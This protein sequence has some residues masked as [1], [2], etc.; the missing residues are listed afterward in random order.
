MPR[1]MS[2]IKH[3]YPEQFFLFDSPYL[4]TLV[5][6]I[7]QQSTTQPQFNQLIKSVY[8]TMLVTALNQEWPRSKVEIET[9]MTSL[10]PDQRLTS[11]VFN[12]NQKA[13]CVD[14]ARAGMLPSQVFFDEL[15]ELVD[16]VKIRQ[17][18]IFAARMTDSENQVTHTELNSSKIG[19]DVDQCLVFLPDPMGATGL[20][21]CQVID[22]YKKQVP[23]K[24][25]KYIS[26]HLIVTP[27]FIRQVITKHPDVTI[28][29]AR[30]DRGFSSTEVLAATPG[31]FWDQ[32]IGLNDSQYIVPGAGGV[33]ELINNSYV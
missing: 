27:E 1:H 3:C 20:S 24:A 17:D 13:V 23:G 32:E 14:I 25:L 8:K 7:S 2:Q 6:K 22:H 16:P 33:G 18:H 11:E 28:Y 26:V 19:G 9:R 5:T 10:H 31:K 30:L 15:C 4:S 12:P 29:A 21:L